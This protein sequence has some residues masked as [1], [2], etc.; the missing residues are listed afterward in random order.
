MQ[1]CSLAFCSVQWM[2]CSLVSQFLYSF[3]FFCGS[4]HLVDSLTWAA[5]SIRRV[6]E[7][8]RYHRCCAVCYRTACVTRHVCFICLLVVLWEQELIYCCNSFSSCAPDL[9]QYLGE[10]LPI[11]HCRSA[12]FACRLW[13][14]FQPSTVRRACVLWLDDM[15]AGSVLLAALFLACSGNGLPRRLLLQTFQKIR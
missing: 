2:Q 15:C 14:T 7:E 4:A 5:V 11:K 6:C 9:L 8:K 13:L 3:L 1:S 10:H 12:L